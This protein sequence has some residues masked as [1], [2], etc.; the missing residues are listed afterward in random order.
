MHHKCWAYCAMQLRK[1][2]LHVQS[3]SCLPSGYERMKEFSLCSYNML[4]TLLRLPKHW[5]AAAVPG[6]RTPG[7]DTGGMPWWA[8]GCPMGGRMMV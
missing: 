4:L 2:A 7:M 8:H 6:F 1:E 5:S 3:A